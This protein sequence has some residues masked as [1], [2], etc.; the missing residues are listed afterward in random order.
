MSTQARAMAKP[1]SRQLAYIRDLNSRTGT[2]FSYPGTR[3]GA[4]RKIEHLTALAERQDLAI[5]RFTKLGE[6]SGLPPFDE[7]RRD[8]TALRFLWNDRKVMVVI[9]LE[10]DPTDP[11]G[12]VANDDAAIAA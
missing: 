1:T 7:V 10:D 12:T 3:G 11:G 2:D 4:R 8:G 6:E 5:E 9:D